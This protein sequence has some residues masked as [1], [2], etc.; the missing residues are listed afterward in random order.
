[1]RET[2]HSLIRDFDSLV[3]DETDLYLRDCCDH[4]AQIIDIIETD[5]ELCKDLGDFF[6]TV[7][8]HR[9]NQVMKFL[10]IIATLF[11]PLSFISGLYGMNF[12]TQAST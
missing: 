11:I 1:M 9:M 2:I 7:A 6:L 8:S 3:S 10:T 5:Q 12:N 4:T